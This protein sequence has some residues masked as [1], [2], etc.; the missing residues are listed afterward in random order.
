MRSREL[1]VTQG[2]EKYVAL[3]ERYLVGHVLAALPRLTLLAYYLTNHHS[4]PNFYTSA[5]EFIL[6]YPL[7]MVVSLTGVG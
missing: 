6:S 1:T 3:H 5:V 7:D 4:S 2:D